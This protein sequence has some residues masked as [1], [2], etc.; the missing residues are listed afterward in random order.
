MKAYEAAVVCRV[1]RP[2][3]WRALSREAKQFYVRLSQRHIPDAGR[4]PTPMHWDVSRHLAD[5]GEAHRNSF[6]WG[7]FYIDIGL[8]ELEEDE[9][10]RC[11]MVDTPASFFYGTDQ[12]LPPRL[13]QH[14]MLTSLGWDVRRVRWDDWAEL[15]LDSERKKPFLQNLL[16]GVRPV[17]DELVDKSPGSPGAVKEKLRKFR[18]VLV[19]ADEVERAAREDRKI[20]FD[21]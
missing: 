14:K 17:G 1:H 12:Y 18:E 20:D 15:E 7:P 6:R 13:L 3:A 9:R 16:A 11:L 4:E 19:R 2:N 8:E 21:I 5:L 10:R